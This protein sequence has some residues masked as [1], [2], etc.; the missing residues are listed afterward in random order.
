MIPS[1]QS[2]LIDVVID[3]AGNEVESFEVDEFGN[4]VHTLR[5][6]PRVD[7]AG[8]VVGP[9]IPPMID[10]AGNEVLQQ[11]RD[12]PVRN[13]AVEGAVPPVQDFVWDQTPPSQKCPGT[14]LGSGLSAFWDVGWCV[15]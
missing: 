11:P 13:T 9:H 15:E 10:E 6:D 14:R 2:A 1:E 12:M 4:E 3:E 7:E 8:N 5:L